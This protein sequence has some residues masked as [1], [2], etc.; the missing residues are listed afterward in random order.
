MTTRLTQQARFTA[1]P[2]PPSRRLP[3]PPRQ[4][5]APVAIPPDGTYEGDPDDSD[6]DRRDPGNNG[7]W[8]L[9]PPYHGPYNST[10]QA[11]RLINEQSSL[12]GYT[13]VKA[14]N[15]QAYNREKKCYRYKLVCQR[16]GVRH[17]W[18]G[19]GMSKNQRDSTSRRDKCPMQVYLEAEGGKYASI[20]ESTKWFI[21][22][23][24]D[25][26]CEHNHP[27]DIARAL[28]SAR[29]NAIRPAGPHIRRLHNAGISRRQIA[30]V[31][32]Q[33]HPEMAPYLIPK[34]I[35]NLLA[36]EDQTAVQTIG[37]TTQQLMELLKDDNKYWIDGYTNDDTGALEWLLVLYYPLFK[38]FYKYH[39]EII[40]FDCTY[41]TNK[42]NLPLMNICGVT[43][44]GTTIPLGVALLSGESQEDFEPILLNLKAILEA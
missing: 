29:S 31:I 3:S 37:N 9:P 5:Q 26:E 23:V 4:W 1:S 35:S 41:S 30:A 27:P 6:G 20:D 32:R 10:D 14:R 22:F 15:S 33:D 11:L 7:V 25:K 24:N 40:H 39:P 43:G 28:P 21:K 17:D 2:T 38:K 36:I 42:Y 44:Q 19:L 13:L 8:E 34:D 18:R 12:D 16:H